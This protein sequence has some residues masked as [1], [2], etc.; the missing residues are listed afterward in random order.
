MGETTADVAKW[1]RESSPSP[2]NHTE[3]GGDIIQK[4]LQ[5]YG[6]VQPQTKKGSKVARS[7]LQNVPEGGDET[8]AVN[9]TP[10]ADEK[11]GKLTKEGKEKK[12][13][14]SEIHMLLEKY[15]IKK[16]S[17][18]A[19]KKFRQE[20]CLQNDG[21]QDEMEQKA[22]SES[23][24]D[25]EGCAET[26][27]NARDESVDMHENEHDI[28][29]SHQEMSMFLQQSGIL[30]KSIR[31]S[32]ILQ[33]SRIH[34]RMSFCDVSNLDIHATQNQTLNVFTC[35]NA[36]N[37]YESG[38]SFLLPRSAVR[39]SRTVPRSRQFLRSDGVPA[40]EESQ[41]NVSALLQQ[42]GA[43]QLLQQPDLAGNT[44]P[45]R[46][47]GSEVGSSVT[48]NNISVLLQHYGGF[49]PSVRASKIVQDLERSLRHEHYRQ[50]TDSDSDNNKGGS[51][52]AHLVN[53]N[54]VER[55]LL[56]RAALE[57]YI[58]TEGVCI[59]IYV[60]VCGWE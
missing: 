39:A 29:L 14:I 21:M 23:K 11:G 47:H 41:N 54:A 31:A 27:Q 60:C 37:A 20:E 8:A 50:V 25:N 5:Q 22:E 40:T 59:C 10:K 53:M 12:A 46:Q 24:G 13:R 36:R 56:L 58:V 42:Y 7:T 32:R 4:L 48:S 34:T 16:P 55:S 28:S 52:Y 30:E 15:G 9:A 3:E 57:Q 44:M 18:R 38:A 1:L 17:V 49:P 51:N 19:S 2:D 33:A 35:E 43:V 6:I 45:S 26:D